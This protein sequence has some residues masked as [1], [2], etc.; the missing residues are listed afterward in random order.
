MIRLIQA[1]TNTHFEIARKLFLEYS[2]SL[3][4]DLDFQDFEDE[5]KDIKRIY[6]PPDGT[7]ILAYRDTSLAG[8]VGMHRL[9]ETICEMKRLY[10]MPQSRGL[11]LGRRLAYAIIE[12]AREAGYLFMRLDTITAM[13]RAINLY[14]SLGF[15]EIDSYRHNPHEGARFYEL[16]L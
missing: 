15:D 2:E 4:F 9:G 13:T 11:G 7:I 12:R 14:N 16:K 5:L 1:E 8:C 10:V 3:D 6:S